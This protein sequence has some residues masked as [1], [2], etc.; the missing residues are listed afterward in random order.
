MH[1]DYVIVD[2]IGVDFNYRYYFSTKLVQII[3]QKKAKNETNLM[4][5]KSYFLTGFLWHNTHNT[6]VI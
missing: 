6:K 4:V 3:Y 5:Y 2:I 1:F